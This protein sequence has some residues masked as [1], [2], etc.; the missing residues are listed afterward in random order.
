MKMK[1]NKSF[2][3]LFSKEWIYFLEESTKKL[4]SSKPIAFSSITP[5]QI[6]EEAGVY[7]ISEI[8]E[9]V[10]TALYIGRSKNLRNRIYRNHLMGNPINA[11][12]K[13]YMIQV[14]KHHAFEDKVLAKQ[15]IRANCYA[16][17]I[18]EADLKKRGAL[19]GYFTARF[20]PKYGISEEH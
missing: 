3:N 17:W 13:K 11:R 16:R 15:Y 20:F 7:I 2:I 1:M 8:I 5:S 6:P 9:S 19:E 14:E 12:L 4:Y 10:E 18:L